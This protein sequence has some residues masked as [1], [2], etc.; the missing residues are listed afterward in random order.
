MLLH[1][2]TFLS[3]AEKSLLNVPI[4][5]TSKVIHDGGKAGAQYLS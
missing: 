4:D 1:E 2:G 5:T 3:S